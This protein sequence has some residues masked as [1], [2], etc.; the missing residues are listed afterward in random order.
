MEAKKYVRNKEEKINIILDST[1]KL[2][3]EN[4]YEN[5]TI[6][7]IS[8]EANVSVGLIYKYFPGGKPEI[9]RIIGMKFVNELTAANN[10]GSIDFDD[11]PGFLRNFFSNNLAYFKNNKRFITALVL[12]AV[13]D[14]KVHEI[15]EDVDEK[16]MMAI[17]NFF[18]RFK[19]VDISN[20]GES[21]RFMA[22]W[23]DVTK[24]IMLHHAIYPTPFDSDEEVIELLVKI[25]LM[26]WDYKNE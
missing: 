18:G 26:M 8:K 21:W 1:K 12:S 2:I 23:S 10:P 24:H 5:V 6:R 19:G 11:F 14:S 7:D 3:E 9:V 16:K 4:K 15:F 17:F 25:S 20:K 22:K 13:Q